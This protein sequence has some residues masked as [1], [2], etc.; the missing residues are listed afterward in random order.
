MTPKKPAPTFPEAL[1]TVLDYLWDDERRAYE[2]APP[3]E[4]PRHVF[5]SLRVLARHR[6]AALCDARDRLAWAVVRQLLDA[7]ARGEDEGGHIDW[8]DL[9]LAHELACDAVAEACERGQESRGGRQPDAATRDADEA[10]TGLRAFAA[11]LVDDDDHDCDLTEELEY[12]CEMAALFRTLDAALS[13]GAP[14][15][16]AWR[17]L[18]KM[19]ASLAKT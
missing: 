10:L 16:R 15:P 18:P 5:A 7:Y 17:S 14:R 8:D 3:D 12:A 11:R 19:P 13:A 2:A 9:D 1:T 6:G 4:R